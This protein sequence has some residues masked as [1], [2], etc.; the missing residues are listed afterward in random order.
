MSKYLELA[1]LLEQAAVLLR[2][3]DGILLG[4]KSPATRLLQNCNG[5]YNLPVH[6][7]KSLVANYWGRTPIK[8]LAQLREQ[9]EVELLDRKNIGP[10]CIKRIEEFLALNKE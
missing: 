7:R 3:A 4:I 6:V 2:E 5:Y 9:T 10:T 1:E 8:T